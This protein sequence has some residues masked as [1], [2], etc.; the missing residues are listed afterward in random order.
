MASQPRS[1]PSRMLS[2]LMSPRR[3]TTSRGSARRWRA[4]AAALTKPRRGGL[5][6]GRAVETRS[7]AGPASPA[8][9]RRAWSLA[10][11]SDDRSGLCR[12]PRPGPS[13]PGCACPWRVRAGRLALVRQH[14]G[15]AAAGIPGHQGRALALFLADGDLSASRRPPSAR[16]GMRRLPNLVV[17]GAPRPGSRRQRSSQGR[18]RS[19]PT[20]LY[21]ARRA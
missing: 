3:T 17:N 19:R 10:V 12:R 16:T 11:V 5:P 20:S 4:A 15:R 9:G 2:L 13:P 7:A 1:P 8:A 21:G 6:P 18:R 14:P